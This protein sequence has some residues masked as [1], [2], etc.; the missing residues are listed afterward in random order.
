[1]YKYNGK[2]LQD[3]SIGGFQL[4]WYDME[5][6][7]YMPDIGRWGSIDE[8]AESFFNFSPYDFSNNN[9]VFFSD[10]SGLAPENPNTNYLASTVVNS[11]GKVLDYKNDGDT[12]I[13]LADDNWKVGSSRTGLPIIGHEKAGATYYPGQQININ[14][15][16]GVGEVSRIANGAATPIGGAFDILGFWDM[17][18]QTTEGD[19]D[20]LALLFIMRGKGVNS[21][22]IGIN[23]SHHLVPK[24]VF[25]ALKRDLKALMKLG[26]KKNLINLTTPFHGNHPQ[27][28]AYVK[29]VL[30]E[31]KNAGSLSKASIEVLQNDLRSIISNAAKEYDKTGKNLNEY[32]RQLNK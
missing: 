1:K 21:T 8:L 2:E 12:N 9:P 29:N 22:N 23:N 26:S 32:F 25:K 28:S 7:N 16:T 15:L 3:E 31:L 10:P 6:R 20:L 24:A 4:N 5:A 30:T 27:Y 11:R 14:F 18:S 19:S 17:L 13:Y